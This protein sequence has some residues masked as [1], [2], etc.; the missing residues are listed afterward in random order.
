VYRHGVVLLLR[1]LK[2]AARGLE[3]AHDHGVVH[4]DI[5]LVKRPEDRQPS[6]GRVAAELEA[7]KKGTGP[8]SAK[9]PLGLA[10]K[11]GVR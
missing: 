6:M 7:A 10:G 2:T 3:Y 1:Q 8:I 11:L 9:H 4:R 5:K